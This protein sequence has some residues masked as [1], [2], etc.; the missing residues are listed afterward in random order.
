[1]IQKQTDLQTNMIINLL[2]SCQNFLKFN[3]S[4]QTNSHF[5]FEELTMPFVVEHM[6]IY[7]VNFNYYI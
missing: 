1:M 6:T 4:I 5:Y 7:S 3:K 2:M